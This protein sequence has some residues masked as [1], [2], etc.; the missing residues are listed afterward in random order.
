MKNVLSATAVLNIG[1]FLAGCA[2]MPRVEMLEA[3]P[4][5]RAVLF[6][7]HTGE[8][9]QWDDM[10]E[11]A[12]A[13]DAVFIGESHGHPLGLS[14]AAAL[15]D[16]IL[17]GTDSAA[18]ALEFF[19]RDQQSIIDD[20]LGD[21]VNE[22]QFKK[23]A[24]R[25]AGNYPL[26]HSTMIEAAKADD[27]PV[28]AANAPRRYLRIGRDGYE[29]YDAFTNEQRRLFAV[30]DEMPSGDYHDNFVELMSGMFAAHGS[31]DEPDE[32]GEPQKTDEEIEA[33][34]NAEI[35]KMFR[36]QSVWDATMSETV[37]RA[38]ALG[39]SPVVLVI[40]NFHVRDHGGTVQLFERAL[41]GASYVVVLVTDKAGDELEEE[42]MG[43]ADYVLYVG[44]Q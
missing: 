7:G 21:V 11:R 32:S 5:T 33:E 15:W 43:S 23:L 36:S 26:G 29:G 10:V 40:G 44:E 30:P 31:D 38:M 42:D 12:R 2:S 17:E 39:N 13:A 24:R 28:F 19:E 22:A 27:R 18:L 34:M 6:D 20:Y 8:R 4:R 16:D 3:Q 37:A 9:A 41:P 25:K 1:M 14:A 35:A